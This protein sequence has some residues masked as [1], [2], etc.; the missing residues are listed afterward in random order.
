MRN[1]IL[2]IL[3]EL[4]EKYQDYAIQGILVIA[5]KFLMNHQQAHTV[6]VIKEILESMD[7]KTLIEGASME[8]TLRWEDLLKLT[9]LS[10]CDAKEQLKVEGQE[11]RNSEVALSILGRFSED[12]IVFQ[13]K[14][15]GV[16]DI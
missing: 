7:A 13:S 16:F 3:N 11:W 4:I 12:I 2:N 9:E 10:G 14:Q 8:L 5:E 1:K 15:S 6:T